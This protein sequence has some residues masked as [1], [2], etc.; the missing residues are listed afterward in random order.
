MLKWHKR[1]VLV[2][3]RQDMRFLR[4]HEAHKLNFNET[5]AREQLANVRNSELPDEEKAGRIEAISA[6]IHEAQ[7]TRAEY[8]KLE[9]MQAELVP[10]I[11]ML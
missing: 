4:E 2:E 1:R 10:Y 8:E 6:E 5:D 7:A 11:E 3:V 9:K